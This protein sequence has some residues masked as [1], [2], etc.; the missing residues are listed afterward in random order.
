MKMVEKQQEMRKEIWMAPSSARLFALFLI[1]PVTYSQKN[2]SDHH[3]SSTIES[4]KE[5]IH[6]NYVFANRTNYFNNTLDSLN[7]TGNSDGKKRIL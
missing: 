7:L 4:I 5:L 1:K 6:A 3:K 2:I